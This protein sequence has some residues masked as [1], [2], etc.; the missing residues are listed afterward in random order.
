MKK[1]IKLILGGIYKN[2]R[3]NQVQITY[4][5]YDPEVVGYEHLVNGTRKDT[6]PVSLA[7]VRSILRR[8]N[9]KFTRIERNS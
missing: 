6:E 5:S 9:Y 2:S 3:G 4:L 8:G 7:R 1:P